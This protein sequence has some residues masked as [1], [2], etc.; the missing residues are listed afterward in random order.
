VNAHYGRRSVDVA[1]HERDASFDSAGW[2]RVTRTAGFRL[3]DDAFK[4]VDA[5]MSPAGGE[6][7]FSYLADR[8]RGHA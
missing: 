7:C 2:G 1:Q 4:T 6:V 3:C 5:E 8:D